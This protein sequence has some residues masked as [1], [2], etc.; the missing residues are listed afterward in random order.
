DSF[1]ALVVCPQGRTGFWQPGSDDARRALGILG[2]VKREFN[3]D[4]TRIY[5]S[6][7]SSGAAGVWDLAA[8]DPGRWAAIVPVASGGCDPA[9][10]PRIRHIPCWCFHNGNDITSPPEGPRQ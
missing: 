10:A 4:P 3:V 8:S 6:G 7:V 9:L 2:R 1:P 5:L